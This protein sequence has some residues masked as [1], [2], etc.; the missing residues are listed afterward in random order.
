MLSGTT[1]DSKY[2]KVSE[3]QLCHFRKFCIKDGL[4]HYMYQRQIS[5][6]YIIQL[7]KYRIKK[8]VFK[9]YK[10]NAYSY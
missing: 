5:L 2:Q 9:K 1:F 6:S 10:K 4:F 3:R 7:C 8:E